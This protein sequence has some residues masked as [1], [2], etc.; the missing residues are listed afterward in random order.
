LGPRET[1]CEDDDE[2]KTASKYLHVIRYYE[3]DQ[4]ENE[5]IGY[6]TPNADEKCVHNS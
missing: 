4:I 5:L 6:V 2:Y 1:E 3:G